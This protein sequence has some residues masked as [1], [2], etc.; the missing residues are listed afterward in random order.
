MFGGGGYMTKKELINKIKE[1]KRI[2]DEKFTEFSE[3]AD[4]ALDR[5]N[6][7]EGYGASYV[8]YCNSANWYAGALT[9]L[10][11]LEKFIKEN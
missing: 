1:L 2:N 6:H 3:S 5:G 11:D 8:F 10:E 4:S 7:K 9:M